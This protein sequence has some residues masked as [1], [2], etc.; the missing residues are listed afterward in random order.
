MQ[1]INK[2]KSETLIF[3]KS[4]ISQKPNRRSILDYCDY[5]LN[6]LTGGP[7]SPLIPCSPATPGGPLNKMI[8][9]CVRY[10][11]CVDVRL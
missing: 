4:Q 7:D 3:I 5:Q 11:P 8:D 2:K 10:R 9:E 6:I 1:R